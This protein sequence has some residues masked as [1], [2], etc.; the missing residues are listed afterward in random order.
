MLPNRKGP[1]S[2]RS[3]CRNV[4]ATPHC[5][6]GSA[7]N[8]EDWCFANQSRSL[9]RESSAAE[10]VAVRGEVKRVKRR[11]MS[12]DLSK[13]SSRHLRRPHRSLGGLGFYVPRSRDRPEPGIRSPADRHGYS[14]EFYDVVSIYRFLGVVDPF[15]RQSDGAVKRLLRSSKRPLRLYAQVS[16]VYGSHDPDAADLRGHHDDLHGS[17]T[18]LARRVVSDSGTGGYAFSY[19]SSTIVEKPS[20]WLGGN[21]EKNGTPW[22]LS[23][24]WLKTEMRPRISSSC[25]SS[26]KPTHRDGWH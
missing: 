13:K 2:R 22:S 3:V 6:H 11:R 9:S 5:A 26:V 21:V 25:G 20:N 1:H 10:T 8:Y 4:I 15:L 19:R 18:S 12:G 17:D 23:L 7:I 14:C 24:L 16:R